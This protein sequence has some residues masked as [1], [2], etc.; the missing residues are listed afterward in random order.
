MD[1]EVKTY[2][3]LRA[4]IR[5][6]CDFLASVGASADCIFDS[7]LAMSELIGNVLRHSDGVAFVKGNIQ[8]DVVV[9]EICSSTPFKP[10]QK[11]RLVDVYAEH[12]RGLYLVDTVCGE[13]S[14]GEDGGICIKIKINR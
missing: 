14:T 5:E 6:F 2:A 9:L 8:D 11:S 12:G 13:R 7:R 10:P 4:A 1:F 3:A